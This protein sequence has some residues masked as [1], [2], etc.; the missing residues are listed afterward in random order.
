MIPRSTDRALVLQWF[1]LVPL[2]K[3]SGVVCSL[4][5]VALIFFLISFFWGGQNNILITSDYCFYILKQLFEFKKISIGVCDRNGSND[6]GSAEERTEESRLR[7]RR[8][9]GGDGGSVGEPRTSQRKKHDTKQVEK[10]HQKK[11][12]VG[13]ERNGK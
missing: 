13:G 5:S 4:F 9:D 8:D 11:E 3:Y 7:C 2:D 6:G 1:L 12:S 10:I